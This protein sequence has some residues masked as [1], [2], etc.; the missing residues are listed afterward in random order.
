MELSGG[1]L[2]QNGEAPSTHN[3]PTHPPSYPATDR[4]IVESRE[5]SAFLQWWSSQRDRLIE[6]QAAQH[7]PHAALKRWW[8]S[9]RKRVGIRR[10]A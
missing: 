4:R 10:A 1:E 5:A 3:N 6:A 2:Q 7:L 9:I 8:R